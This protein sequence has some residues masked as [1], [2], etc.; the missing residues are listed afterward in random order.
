MHGEAPGNG[1]LAG[2]GWI[3]PLG[4]CA[5]LSQATSQGPGRSSRAGLVCLPGH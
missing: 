3:Q 4:G 5:G 1:A 2:Q